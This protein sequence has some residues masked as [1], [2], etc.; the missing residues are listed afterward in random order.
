MKQLIV[1]T[2][3]DNVGNALEDIAPGDAVLWRQADSEHGLNAAE[4][5]PF[6][7]KMALCAIVAGQEIIC[8]GEPSARPPRTL[9]PGLWFMC[10]MCADCAATP[11]DR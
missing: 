10:T 5:V 8:Y 2:A 11:T 6:A 3:N 7:F 9:Q 4:A 1:K